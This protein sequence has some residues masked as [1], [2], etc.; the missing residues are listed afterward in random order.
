MEDE[1]LFFKKGDRRLIRRFGCMSPIKL[2][3]IYWLSSI[4]LNSGSGLTVTFLVSK[5]FP[6]TVSVTL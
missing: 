1:P 5:S 6:S 4:Y 3:F 2:S